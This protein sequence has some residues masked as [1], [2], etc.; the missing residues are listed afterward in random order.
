MHQ[1]DSRLGVS[2][3]RPKPDHDSGGSL[4]DGAHDLDLLAAFLDVSLVDSQS[5]NPPVPTQ[6]MGRIE[7]T[8]SEKVVEILAHT[9]IVPIALQ[10]S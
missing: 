8:L 6:V 2:I 9:A 1:V 10:L 3:F 5:V 7:R 4:I